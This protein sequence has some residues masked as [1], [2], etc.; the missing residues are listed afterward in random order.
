MKIVDTLQEVG[1]QLPLSGLISLSS[2]GP[3]VNKT[4]W[5]TVNKVLV[6]EGLPGLMP[7]IP[8]NIHVVHNAFRAGLNS[9]GEASEE[10]AIDLFYW[11]KSSPSRREDYGHVLSREKE[12]E[13]SEE[14]KESELQRAKTLYEEANDRLLKAVKNKN[15][16]EVTVAQGLLE[17]AKKKMDDVMEQSRQCSSKRSQRTKNKK[18][19]LEGYSKHLSSK[20]KKSH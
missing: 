12:L 13:K 15:F 7:F 9:Y 18:R 10:L 5:N 14:L 4:I 2:D 8:C 17:V 3:N 16:N 19:L 11:L 20:K 6:D 1:Y